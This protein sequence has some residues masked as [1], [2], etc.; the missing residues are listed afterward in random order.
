MTVLY[1]EDDF[2]DFDF[3]HEVVKSIDHSTVFINTRDGKETLNYLELAK[4]LPD[5]IFLDINMPSMDGKACLKSI[6]QDARFKSIP[7]VVY[8]TSR[9]PRDKDQCLQLGAID[10]LQKANGFEQTARLLEKF[11]MR[12]AAA[13]A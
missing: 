10:Y 13:G 6:R 12:G 1:A 2:E 5:I 4:V 11:F 3:F 7:V 8:T 9:D